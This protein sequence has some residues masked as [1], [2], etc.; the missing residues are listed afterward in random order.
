MA[1]L[2]LPM[3]FMSFGDL[4]DW[5]AFL[6][7]L[8]QTFQVAIFFAL[9]R[10]ECVA[11]AR[12]EVGRELLG[13]RDVGADEKFVIPGGAPVAVVVG[14]SLFGSC[15]LLMIVTGWRAMGAAAAFVAAMF[16]V[17]FIELRVRRDHWVAPIHGGLEYSGAL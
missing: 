12:N 1:F 8:A 4:V 17:K 15:G 6:G 2:I 11:R 14:A 7:A 5:S 9:R 10:P 3:Q 16:A 13:Q